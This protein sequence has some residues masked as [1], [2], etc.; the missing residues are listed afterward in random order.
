VERTIARD[1]DG[2]DNVRS[3]KGKKRVTGGERRRDT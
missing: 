1:G 3:G 2:R